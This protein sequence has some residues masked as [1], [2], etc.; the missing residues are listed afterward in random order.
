MKFPEPP[1][2]MPGGT[3]RAL[4]RVV[5]CVV[6]A[7]RDAHAEVEEAFVSNKVHVVLDVLVPLIIVVDD[8][9]VGVEVV[10]EGGDGVVNGGTGLDK[11]DDRSRTLEGDNEV[12]RG[13]LA[14]EREGAF[15]V[16]TIYDLHLEG[17]G[18]VGQS[19]HSGK[20]K[21]ERRSGGS[22]EW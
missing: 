12:A 19:L 11:D 9:I 2:A 4:G 7:A 18:L 14:R 1:S 17:D 13:V 10:E 5:A 21:G 8:A 3:H 16:C 6:F 15:I 20:R 22:V